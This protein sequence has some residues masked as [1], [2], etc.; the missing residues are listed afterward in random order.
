MLAAAASFAQN[1]LDPQHSLHISLPEDSPVT[2]LQANWGDSNASARGGA[3][4]LDLH[5]SLTFK[6]TGQRRIRGITLLVKAQE[7]TP[8]GK[9]SVSVPSLNVAPG[10][11]FP[12]RIDLGLLRPLQVG[13]GP[14]VEIALDGILFDDL[15]FYGPNKLNSKRSMT[16]WELEARRDRKHFKNILESAG[17]MALQDEMLACLNRQTERSSMEARVAQSGRSTNAI[18]NREVRFAFL[19]M[20]DAPV[21]FSAGR[22]G[23][24]GDEASKPRITVDSH[25][26]RQISAMEVGWLLTDSSGR[27]YVAGAIPL[28]VSLAPH[29]STTVVQD[30]AF[31]FSRPNGEPIKIESMTGY[32]NSVEFADGRMWIPNRSKLLPTPSPEEQRLTELYRKKGPRALMDELRK[33]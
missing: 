3:M 24:T 11:A 20:P 18:T 33:F 28:E 7:V 9:A 6:N 16:V 14:L 21:G 4:L 10:E 32:V 23:V 8:G 31:K 2:L 1:R 5:T 29:Q 30:A 12:L 17:P 27:K 25:S 22:V 13:N 15:T 19:E 26:D